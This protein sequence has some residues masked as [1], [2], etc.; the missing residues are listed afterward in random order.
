MK[1]PTSI[2]ISLERQKTQYAAYAPISLRD[3][4]R[5]EKLEHI[6][7]TQKGYEAIGPLSW[8]AFNVRNKPLDGYPGPAGHFVF[9]R[10]QIHKSKT[11]HR[12]V[13]SGH[14][15]FTPWKSLLFWRC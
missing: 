11:A 9:D 13:G 14:R 10:P 3:I 12:P 15:T 1:D 4:D 2:V 6:K 5:L 8:L 7:V